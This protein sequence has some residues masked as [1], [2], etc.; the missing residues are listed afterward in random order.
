MT[1]RLALTFAAALILG[2]P[3]AAGAQTGGRWL[4]GAGAGI[5]RTWDD[6]SMLGAGVLMEGRL[7]WALTEKTQIE[8]GITH[9]PYE[10]RFESGV[11]TEGRSI[12]TGLALK[13]DFT[14][15]RVR[16]F[17]L[18]GYGLNQHRGTREH[19]STPIHETS[20]TDHGYF[21]GTG[22]VVRNGRWEIGPEA[23]F[24]MLSIE[25]DSS[26]ATILAGA[27]RASVRF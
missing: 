21:I 8:L 17:V 19:P 25:N 10:R 24:Y 1:R 9:I 6:E 12:F 2:A 23:R 20:T 14:R 5:A 7:G 18:A 16:P 4:A 15:G 3:A 26:A 22:L 13:Y 27:V 11:A